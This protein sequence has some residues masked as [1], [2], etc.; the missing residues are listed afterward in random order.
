M[1][2]FKESI[3]T[4]ECRLGSDGTGNIETG[5]CHT[6]AHLITKGLNPLKIVN[7]ALELADQEDSSRSKRMSFAEKQGAVYR[8]FETSG[9]YYYDHDGRLIVVESGALDRK[10]RRL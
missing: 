3:S 6:K 5:K 1:S 8:S 2:R 10:K 4:K 9:C 7:A